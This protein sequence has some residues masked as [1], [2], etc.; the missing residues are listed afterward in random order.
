MVRAGAPYSITLPVDKNP[1]YPETTPPDFFCL[2]PADYLRLVAEGQTGQGALVVSGDLNISELTGCASLPKTLVEGNVTVSNCPHLEYCE[3]ETSGTL[4]I[5]GCPKLKE[6]RGRVGG[7]SIRD[8]GIEILGAG[9]ECDGDLT[10]SGCRSFGKV[11]CRVGGVL[12][13]SGKGIVGAGPAFSCESALILD[14]GVAFFSWAKEAPR[15]GRD[16]VD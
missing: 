5:F 6:V 16:G 1:H 4:E 3:I 10:I 9:F 8:C 13:I 11:N 7:G 15:E 12:R 14:G 2:R